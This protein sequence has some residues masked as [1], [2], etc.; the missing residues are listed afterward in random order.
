FRLRFD[1]IAGFPHERRPRVVWIGCHKQPAAYGE[2]TRSLQ[3]A[4]AEFG[5]SF[6]DDPVAHVTIARIKEAR[7]PLPSIDGFEPID[8]GVNALTLFESLPAGGTTRYEARAQAPL[9]GA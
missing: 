1:R 7:R 6:K 5:F 8:A 2:L 4:Y 9:S 3:S